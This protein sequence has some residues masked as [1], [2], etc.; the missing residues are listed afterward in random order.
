[1]KTD[2]SVPHSPIEKTTSLAD[3]LISTQSSEDIE[4]PPSCHPLPCFNSF[5]FR[6]SEIKYLLSELDEY[7]G[8]DPNSLFP[9]ILKTKWPISS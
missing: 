2:V 3:C 9:L 6:S 7:G 8:I 5:A 1:M 4:L